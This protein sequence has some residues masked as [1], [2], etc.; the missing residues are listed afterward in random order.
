MS[1]SQA[2]R[3]TIMEMISEYLHENQTHEMC[4][5]SE[6]NVDERLDHLRELLSAAKMG[7]TL[8]RDHN[9]AWGPMGQSLFTLRFDYNGDHTEVSLVVN[10]VTSW[11]LDQQHN[12]WLREDK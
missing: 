6:D 1:I 10:K 8:T 11:N 3:R 2:D 7:V 9:G 4:P 12:A 5:L